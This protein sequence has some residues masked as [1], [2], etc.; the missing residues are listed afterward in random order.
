[1]GTTKIEAR[2]TGEELNFIGSNSRGNEVAM[3]GAGVP[4][5]HMLLM[6]LAGCTGMD[7]L[8]ILQKKRQEVSAVEVEVIGH[9][10]DDYPKP[11]HTIEMHFKVRGNKVSE[12]A[13]ARAIELSMTKYCIV[14]QTLQQETEV[15]ARFTIAGPAD[16]A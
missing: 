6:G 12:T 5:T 1:L 13:V 9:N 11:Y 2:W 4:P 16:Q 15:T 14:G 10:A 8:S 7:V 3:G